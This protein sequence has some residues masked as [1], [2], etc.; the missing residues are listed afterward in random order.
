MVAEIV[1]HFGWT[2][3]V[4]VT[5]PGVVVDGVMRTA[6]NLRPVLDRVDAAELFGGGDACSTTPTRRAWRR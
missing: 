4:G 5:F 2:G 3:P 6:A 1:A